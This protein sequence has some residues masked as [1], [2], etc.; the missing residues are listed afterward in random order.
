MRPLVEGVPH[1]KPP[2]FRYGR[3]N[4]RSREKYRSPDNRTAP[5]EPYTLREHYKSAIG[6]VADPG[7]GPLLE[8]CDAPKVTPQINSDMRKGRMCKRYKFG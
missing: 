3:E 7:V 6:I 4:D 5:T 1:K 2:H 8:G